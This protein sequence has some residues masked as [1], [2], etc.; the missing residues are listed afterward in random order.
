MV[1]CRND[2]VQRSDDGSDD[3]QW[4]CGECWDDDYHNDNH[5]CDWNGADATAGAVPGMICNQDQYCDDDEW[6]LDTGAGLDVANSNVEGER[7]WATFL[8]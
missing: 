7:E 2:C 5:T 4:V 8:R 1:G 3:G 6:I